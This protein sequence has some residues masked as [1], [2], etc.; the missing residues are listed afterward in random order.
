MRTR[1]IDISHLRARKITPEDLKIFN[2]IIALDRGNQRYVQSLANETCST[3]VAL[4]MEFTEDWTERD[5]PDP[6][7]SASSFDVVMDMI[8]DACFDLFYELE[9]SIPT[10]KS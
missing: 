9:G 8:E 1:G 6:L 3:T 10:S 5:V 2:R 7:L 4:L